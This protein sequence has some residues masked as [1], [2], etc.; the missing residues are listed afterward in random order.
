MQLFEEKKSNGQWTRAGFLRQFFSKN[1]LFSKILAFLESA[2]RADWKNGLIF[3]RMN[4][5]N[6]PW[7][8]ELA[9]FQVILHTLSAFRNQ[10]IIHNEKI[11][12]KV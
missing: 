6:R 10:L 12:Q 8:E 3:E 11:R 9:D 5:V 7:T 4:Q 2:Q 1:W